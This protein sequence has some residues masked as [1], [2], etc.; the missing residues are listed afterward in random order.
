MSP[1]EEE[2]NNGEK[3]PLFFESLK[4]PDSGSLLKTCRTGSGGMREKGVF[5]L[6]R[7]HRD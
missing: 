6:S 2:M 3:N 5:E 7:G 1:E 4:R